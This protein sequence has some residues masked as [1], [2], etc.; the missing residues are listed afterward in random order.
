[1]LNQ[2]GLKALVRQALQEDA[3]FGDV[4]TQAIV[5]PTTRGIGVFIAK[6]SGVI[7]GSTRR[8]NDFSPCWTTPF[9]F[10][11]FAT[12]AMR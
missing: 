8:P 7:C 5:P 11:P 12:T 1:M 10:A 9:N 4:T 3:P 2:L 6:S